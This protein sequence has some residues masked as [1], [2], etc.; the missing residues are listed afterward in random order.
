M[1]ADAHQRI[2]TTFLLLLLT[3]LY[4]CTGMQ[5]FPL[6]ARAGDTIT[7]AIGS[8]DN[9]TPSN[10]IA[11]YHAVDTNGVEIGTYDLTPGIRNIFKLYP[12]KT[13]Q[14]WHA[15]DTRFMKNWSG[16]GPWMSVLLLDLP[17]DLPQGS[18]W[19][20]VLPGVGAEYPNNAKRVED[21]AIDL[22]I[23][24][25]QGNPHTFGYLAY[26]YDSVPSSGKLDLLNPAPQVMVRPPEVIGTYT[27]ASIGA[28][29]YKLNIPIR[30]SLGNPLADTGDRSTDNQAI[31]VVLDEAPENSEDQIQLSWARQGDE[32][33]VNVHSAMGKMDSGTLRFSILLL[34]QFVYNLLGTIDYD[35][36]FSGIPSVTSVRYFDINGNEV[37][38]G[39]LP[40]IVLRN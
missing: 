24:P 26:L 36:N 27:G 7:L 35:V 3:S 15:T 25:G 37:T 9:I 2:I 39:T 5:P 33:T 21:V 6:S 4:G 23:L 10:T 1:E 12:D 31:R 8:M 34:K 16:H 28:A 30:D 19:V 29:E 18:G 13:S 17:T 11:T 22:E 32:F 40:E 38:V 20:E 14:A